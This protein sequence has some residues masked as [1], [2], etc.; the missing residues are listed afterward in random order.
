MKKRVLYLL[1]MAFAMMAW[2][3]P[4]LWA[5]TQPSGGDGSSESPFLITTAEEL[6]WYANYVN[7]ESGD[8]VVHATACAQLVKDIDLSTVCGEGKGNWTPI[9]KD[10][11]YGRLSSNKFDGVFDGNGHTISNLY[12]NDENGSKLGLF[13]Y[14]YPTMQKTSVKN[15]KMRNVQI[16]GKEYCAAVCGC[17][18]GVTFENIEVISGSIVGSIFIYGI[19]GCGGSARNCINRANVSVERTYAAGIISNI[20]G[21]VSNCSNYGK[22]TAGNGRAGGIAAGSN[23]FTQLI[24]CANYGEIHVTGTVNGT[25]YAVGGLLGCPWNIEISNCAN[26][27]NIYLKAQSDLVGTIAGTSQLKKASGIL[28]NTGNIYVDDIAQTDVPVLQTGITWFNGNVDNTA[29]CLTPTAEQLASGWL[30]W[31]LQLNCG[32][33]T[34]GQNISTEPK[35]AYPVI[36]GSVLYA[37]GPCTGDHS[38]AT[39]F[40]NN[41]SF[42]TH[43]LT[44]HDAV[45]ATCVA[46]GT[47]EYWSC[48][49]CGK[50]W[51]DESG[52]HIV[53]DLTAK[54]LGHDYN[55]QDVCT[56][57]GAKLCSEGHTKDL[58]VDAVEATCTTAGNIGYY[59][60]S[61]CNKYYNAETN[62]QIAENSWKIPAKGHT[63][64]HVS[65]QAATCSKKGNHECWYC[66]GCNT[67]FKEETCENAYTDDADAETGVWIE[68]IPHTLPIEFDENGVKYCSVCGHIEGEAP[69]LVADEAS[70]FNGYYAFSKAGHLVWLHN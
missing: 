15:L 56:R 53:T 14:I 17:G 66:S 27:G 9:A 23:G 28:A 49:D 45:P 58:Q 2:L 39:S 57:C 41:P 29:N 52:Q 20:T 37:A 44:H 7:G 10:G 18:I 19:S 60:C 48:S 46:D 55:A 6:K 26:F 43:N 67:Y 24:N 13:G 31:Q 36:G 22:I 16:V 30:A 70:P 32:I 69:M 68:M 59:H 5:Q 3:P 25:D 40:S 33:Q 12:I 51:S 34:W 11:I 21:E 62:E 8:N 64:N 4:Q 54:A 38:A 63:V 1:C 65:A 50:Q 35:D 42:V 61:V 47:I